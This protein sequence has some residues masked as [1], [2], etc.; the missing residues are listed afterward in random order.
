M[1][2][3]RR[4]RAVDYRRLAAGS[5][6]AARGQ[7]RRS[8]PSS[9]NIYSFDSILSHRGRGTDLSFLVSWSGGHPPT[10]EPRQNLYIHD[11]MDYFSSLGADSINCRAA[12]TDRLVVAVHR[13]LGSA[14]R[15]GQMTVRVPFC[16]ASFLALAA[17][18]G[19]PV[20][21]SGRSSSFSVA[22]C[23]S[24]PTSDSVRLLL[25]TMLSSHFIYRVD[26]HSTSSINCDEPV[27]FR[28]TRTVTALTN[29]MLLVR[30]VG[31]ETLAVS[32]R[33]RWLNG[34]RQ[35]WAVSSCPDCF[36]CTCSSPAN[37]LYCTCACSSR[38]VPVCFYVLPL[39]Y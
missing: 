24:L 7:R 39:L 3:T 31:Q 30:D 10:W 34:G 27:L 33:C 15:R 13:A 18:G 19:L 36:S 29:R 4:R 37:Y 8:T 9:C 38:S 5:L 32:F 23:S 25:E 11:V 26:E 1:V 28:L 22:L 16:R 6:P 20:K 14:R 21:E 2:A 12:D 17:A 35:F